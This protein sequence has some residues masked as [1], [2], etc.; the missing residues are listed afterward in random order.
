MLD[1]LSHGDRSQIRADIRIAATGGVIAAILMGAVV[2]AV[3]NLSSFEARRLLEASL[4]TT[5]F[6]CSAVMTASAT[7]LA[8]MLTML[9]L[10]AGAEHEIKRGHFERIRQIALVDVIAFIAATL[11][12]V[13]L[14]VPFG[15]SSEIPAG[16]YVGLYYGT[17]L[18]AAILGGSLVAVM[19]LLYAAVR[20]LITVVGPG[21]ESPLY[22]DET[23]D[24]EKT[25]RAHESTEVEEAA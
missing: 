21:D 10:T 4:P 20:D 23:S 17:S 1:F 22:A 3:G 11:L 7:T 15:E 24:E 16:W 6:L 12:L 8:L 9:S 13:A 18:M 19:L 2:L 14:V 5:R 25:D